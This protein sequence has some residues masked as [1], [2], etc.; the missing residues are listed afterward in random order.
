MALCACGTVDGTGQN[1]ATGSPA[2]TGQPV[3]TGTGPETDTGL[4]PTDGTASGPMTTGVSF[5]ED[6]DGGGV[7]FECDI[8]AQDCPEGE[9]CMPWAN[10]GGAWNSTRCSPIARDPGQV[11]DSCTVED[12]ATS[13]IDDCELGSVCWAVDP[14]TG[15]GE[16][17]ALCTG[18][19]EAPECEEPDTT[20]FVA[21]EGAIV[22]C[23]PV[24]DPVLE[25][26][27]GPNQGCYPTADGFHCAPDASGPGGAHGD[28]CTGANTCDPGLICINPAFFVDCQEP[29]GCCA[30]ICDTTVADP[31]LQCP[32][33]MDGEQCH[34][35]FDPAPPDLEN[36]GVCAVF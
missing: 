21:N 14:K 13:G 19:A 24:C 29:V 30:T 27:C 12:S 28:G 16:C 23:L 3:A 31:D 1:D 20:C 26:P 8:F 18:S 32:G 11:G 33:E 17:F 10:D 2:T 7:S 6:P 34:P 25:D 5:V 9:K 36:I 4:E 35:L 22:L 15:E